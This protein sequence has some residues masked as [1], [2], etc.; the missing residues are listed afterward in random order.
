MNQSHSL[1]DRL[2]SFTYSDRADALESL[3]KSNQ[4]AK[5][6]STNVNMHMHSFFS[7]NAH[8]YSPTRIA[9]EA[10]QAGLY[11]AGLCDFDVLDGLE[12]FLD[13]TRRIGLRAA[14]NLETRAYLKEYAQHEI[15]SPGEPGV[16]YI[17]GAGFPRALAENTPQHRELTGYRDRARSRN[18]ALVGR[19]N[20]KLPTIAIDY[21]KDV[22]PLTP[23][24]V[25]TERHIISAYIA[26]TKQACGHADATAT[27]L[28]GLLGITKD[29]A[30]ALLADLPTLEEKMRSKLAKQGGL[31]YEQPSATTFPLVDDF[32]AWVRACDAIPMVTWLDGTSSGEKDGRAMLECLAAKGCVALNIIPDRNW[33]IKKPDVQATKVKCLNDIVKHA[34]DMN[35]PIN[36]GTEMNKL[37]LPFADDLDG[38]Y[39]APHKASFLKGARIMVGQSILARYAATSYI[40]KR[41]AAEF[42]NISERNQF[43]EA[44]GAMQALDQDKARNLEAMG[45]D[46]AFSWF[47]DQL[48]ASV[49]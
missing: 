35:L 8:G 12:E 6:S 1:L 48:R 34:D 14:V 29:E 31:G 44:V 27:F 46:K 49:S 22:L 32:V 17:M 42:P 9:W 7:Y 38:T 19:I 40:S 3:I 30:V 21:D 25:A 16:T 37:G 33:N 45:A 36:I 20:A 26:K 24:G 13:A 41:A 5:P 4:S 43:F 10:K 47:Q 39:L 11:G 23:A 15:N 28:G 2:N 18:V